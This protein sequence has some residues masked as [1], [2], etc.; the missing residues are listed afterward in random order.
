MKRFLVWVSLLPGMIQVYAQSCCSALCSAITLNSFSNNATGLQQGKWLV[1]GY[2]ESRC[3]QRYEVMEVATFFPADADTLVSGMAHANLA[4]LK[5]SY[6]LT[7]K[8]TLTVQQPYAFSVQTTILHLKNGAK[9]HELSYW[10]YGL[11]DISLMGNYLFLNEKSVSASLIA[12]VEL[13]TGTT[14][15]N[16]NSFIVGSGSYDPFGGISFMKKWNHFSLKGTILYKK[17]TKGFQDTWFGDFFNQNIILV[18][19]PEASACDT[20]EKANVK[21]NLFTGANG[22]KLFPQVKNDVEISN[23]GSFLAFAFA[24]TTVGIK[25]KWSFPL[26]VEIPFI[27]HINGIQN[28]SSTRIKIGITILI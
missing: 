20:A 21:W 28:K 22:E 2:G 10:N 25:E 12:G 23:T 26:S 1:E 4:L 16:Q 27:Q 9:H 6:G 11:A 14:D 8:F 13:P 17:T 7:S 5:L 24:G 18:Y 19:R 15:L 3:F